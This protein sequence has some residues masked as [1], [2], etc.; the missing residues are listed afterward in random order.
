[1]DHKNILNFA[2]EWRDGETVSE[3]DD[4]IIDT[5]NSVVTKRDTLWLLGD[6]AFSLEGLLRLKEVP[7]SKRLILGNHDQE[8]MAAYLDIFD[9]VGAY[10]KY[11]GYWLSHIPVHAFDFDYRV[12]GNI[13]GHLHNRRITSEHDDRWYRYYNVSV[14]QSYG[15]P[16]PFHSIEKH[17]VDL[18]KAHEEKGA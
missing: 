10:T 11:K 18:A 9:W 14:E 4:W 5:I 2:S 16:V 6:V 8:H 17:M 1:M 15:K 12:K 7:C 13:H 3:H